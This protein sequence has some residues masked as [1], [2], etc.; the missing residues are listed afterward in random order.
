MPTPEYHITCIKNVLIAKDVY[1]IHCEKPE[2]FLYEAGQF[3]LFDVP[4]P[5]NPQDIQ[6]RAYSIASAPHEENLL[7]VVKLLAGG[8]ASRWIQESLTA[9]DTVRMQGPFGR[10]LLDTET[11]ND[12]VF[13]CTSTG[14]APFRSQVLTAL[15]NGDGRRMDIFFGNRQE[16]DLF[17]TDEFEALKTAH[18]NVGFHTIL[19]KPQASWGGHTGY[20]QDFVQREVQDLKE[21]HIYVCGNPT[22]AEEVKQLCLEQWHIPKEHLHVEGFI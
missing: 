19:S 3:I 4:L 6:T 21:K 13:I 10:F 11:E 1:E 7:F 16:E 12:Y 18:P 17:W 15:K 22:M 20:V 9:G 8:R 5:E 14:I 2:G